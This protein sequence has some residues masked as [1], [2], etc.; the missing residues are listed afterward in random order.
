MFAFL[1]LLGGVEKERGERNL[2]TQPHN[3][4]SAL[5]TPTITKAKVRGSQ[6]ALA[7]GLRICS[8]YPSQKA[9]GEKQLSSLAVT[10]F[11]PSDFS[12]L[13][14][15]LCGPSTPVPTSAAKTSGLL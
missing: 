1:L 5:P 10:Y 14:T 12:H 6:Q 4:Q 3:Q 13:A 15:G 2:Q 8:L 7:R 9:R 11:A